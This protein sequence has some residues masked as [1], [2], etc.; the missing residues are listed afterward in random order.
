MTLSVYARGTFGRRNGPG[1][2]PPA[3]GREDPG[4]N[5]PVGEPMMAVGSLSSGLRI[6]GPMPGETA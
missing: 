4:R 6:I 1:R 2:F 5:H 3:A